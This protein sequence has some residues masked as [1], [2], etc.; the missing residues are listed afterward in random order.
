MQFTDKVVSL[1][2]K[3]YANL[4]LVTIKKLVDFVPGFLYF[5]VALF[6][7]CYCLLLL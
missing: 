1:L 5:N 3:K 6:P 2:P 7:L 4:G